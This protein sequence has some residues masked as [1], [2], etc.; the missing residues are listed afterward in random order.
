[1]TGITTR[2]DERQT[3]QTKLRFCPLKFETGNNQYMYILQ[4]KS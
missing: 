1:M 2:K 4:G 3:L